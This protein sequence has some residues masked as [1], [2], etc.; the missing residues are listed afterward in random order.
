M[1][2]SMYKIGHLRCL[3]KQKKENVRTSGWKFGDSYDSRQDTMSQQNACML[4][5]DSTCTK[6][7]AIC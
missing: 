6:G 3:Q 1:I 7:Y 4:L 5:D 2:V